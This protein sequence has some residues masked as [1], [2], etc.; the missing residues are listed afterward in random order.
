MNA[1]EFTKS[2]GRFKIHPQDL[3]LYKTAFTHRSFLNESKEIIESNERLEF[4]GDAVL[5][6]IISTYLFKKRVSDKEGELTNLRAFIVKTDSLAKAAQEL[7]LGKFLR[8]SRG[9]ET[10]G[11]RHNP[12]IL[13]NTFEA[14]LGAIFLDLGIEGASSFIDQLL[15]PIFAKEIAQ[16]APRDPKSRLQEVAQERYQTSP[17]Y[18]VVESSGPDHAK[19]F[20]VEVSISDK[21]WGKG[22][23][24]S[25]QQA[26][27]EA[28][29]EALDTLATT[30]S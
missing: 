16:G 18:K 28:A 15:L 20:I 26:E 24:S 4:L 14:V 10:S 2:L 1:E 9:E 11:G 6:F 8:M 27:E 23:G 30:T 17:R 19:R 21:P 22:S 25:K 3:S 12:Q 13:A 7:S 5:S 29:K